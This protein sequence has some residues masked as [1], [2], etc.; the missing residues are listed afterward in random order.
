[1]VSSAAVAPSSIADDLR[2]PSIRLDDSSDAVSRVPIEPPPSADVPQ[3]DESLDSSSTSLK[4]AYTDQE[5]FDLLKEKYP[6]LKDLQQRFDL[7]GEL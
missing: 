2:T 7:E 4:K 6:H 1:M 3:Q 5:K